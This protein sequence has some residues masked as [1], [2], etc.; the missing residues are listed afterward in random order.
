MPTK[1]GLARPPSIGGRSM[2]PAVDF[3]Q[4]PHIGEAAASSSSSS[5]DDVI[6]IE[7]F[8]NGGALRTNWNVDDAALRPI[9][10][11]HPPLDPQSTA[12]VCDASPSVIAARVSECLRQQSI[13][14]EFYHESASA[15]AMTSNRVHFMI[16]MYQ[17]QGGSSE[18]AVI[19]ELQRLRGDSITFHQ[20]SRAI[21]SSAQGNTTGGQHIFNQNVPNGGMGLALDIPIRGNLRRFTDDDSKE[22]ISSVLLALEIDL[23]LIKKDRMDATILGWESLALLTDMYSSGRSTALVAARVALGLPPTDNGVEEDEDERFAE[24]HATI[25]SVIRDRRLNEGNETMPTV[26]ENSEGKTVDDGD[27]ISNVPPARLPYQNQEQEME[28]EDV[29][30][31][32]VQRS[33]AIRTLANS[34]ATLADVGEERLLQEVAPNLIRENIIPA[35]IEEA[36]LSILPNNPFNASD[37]THAMR[38]LTVLFEASEE[39]RNIGHASNMRAILSKARLVGRSRHAALER[40]AERAFNAL[41][42][43]VARSDVAS[44][45]R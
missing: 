35:L 14:T 21:L 2:A 43:G 15:S 9:P 29:D 33:L 4:R 31:F 6:D 17:G 5:T 32:V 44:M 45:P 27:E 25:I 10:P 11:L 8:R 42:E 41:G 36:A 34:L 12:F 7:S 18:P 13:M 40:E 1:K 38:A 3:N 39:A 20:A 37:A 26:E 24:I 28:I 22:D 16:R 30:H 23:S 19:V